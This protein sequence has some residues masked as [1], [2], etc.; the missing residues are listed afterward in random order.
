[1]LYVL[2]NN[3]YQLYALRRHDIA[4]LAGER[5]VALIA[6][7]HALSLSS[8]MAD[9]ESV[10]C[11]DTP[12]GRVG[13]LSMLWRYRGLGCDVARTFKPGPGD[14]LLFF[15]EVEWLNQIVVQHFRSRGAR[16]VMLEDGGFGTYIPMSVSDSEPL[17]MRERC[18]Q[19]AFRLVPGLAR[20]RL[21]KVN[22]LMFPRLPDEAIDEIA[23]YRDVRLLRDVATYC[24]RKPARKRCEIRRGSVVF[25][26]ERMYDHYQTDEVYIAG[27]R[28]LMRMLTD[29]YETVYF[30]FHPREP[31]DWRVRICELLEREFPSISVIERTGTIEEM[32]LDYRPEALAS[33][34]SAGLL[35][36]EYEG[37]EPLYLYHLLDDLAVQPVFAGVTRILK[38]WGYRFAEVGGVRAGYHSGI[39]DGD[40][41]VSIALEQLLAQSPADAG[42][43]L[44]ADLR[45]LQGMGVHEHLQDD[46]L[47]R[48]SY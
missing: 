47:S 28:R 46:R 32:I 26:N 10:H 30:K 42:R 38:I 20:S 33:Y 6:V 37:I 41:A 34:F 9:F 43:L 31:Q 1:M 36:I 8:D 35:S 5:G 21:F 12:Q 23:L 17:S 4:A 25:L 44:R 7:P 2:V 29:G 45:T 48:R 16:I 22:G 18:I 11:F 3:D 40:P 19:A 27:L 14:T 39:S 15:T 13:L 24:V